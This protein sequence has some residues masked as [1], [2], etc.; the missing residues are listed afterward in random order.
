MFEIKDKEQRFFLF[1][2]QFL[3]HLRPLKG[4]GL[5][6][7]C[8]V[9][10]PCEV[11]RGKCLSG[12]NGEEDQNRQLQFTASIQCSESSQTASWVLSR[13]QTSFYTPFLSSKILNEEKRRVRKWISQQGNSMWPSHAAVYLQYVWLTVCTAEAAVATS[14]LVFLTEWERGKEKMFATANYHFSPK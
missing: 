3:E 2:R 14:G 12:W 13:T 9:C 10:S 6:E 7:T 1:H 8:E 4:G 5:C 11:C